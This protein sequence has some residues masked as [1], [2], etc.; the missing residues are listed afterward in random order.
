M[1]LSEFSEFSDKIIAIAVK[2]LKPLPP[3]HLWIHFRK[4]GVCFE[5]MLPSAQGSF[6]GPSHDLTPVQNGFHIFAC[7]V[8][9][10]DILAANMPVWS[11]YLYQSTVR[12]TTHK[13]SLGQRS[14]FHVCVILFQHVFLVGGVYP[15][16]YFIWGVYVPQ[17]AL[18]RGG[19]E[20]VDRGVDRECTP[21][22]HERS[23]NILF[24]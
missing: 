22:S 13:W 1:F 21:K 11:A 20:C 19:Q 14:V 10:A 3:S 15:R 4:I 24:N 9:P 16:M 5:L 23:Q 7:G 6:K 8:T 17:H 18:C 2:G 12:M